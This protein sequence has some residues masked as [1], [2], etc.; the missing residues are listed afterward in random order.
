MMWP[1]YNLSYSGR[2]EKSSPN[3]QE[4]KSSLPESEIKSQVLQIEKAVGM[5]SVY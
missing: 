5:S 3:F 4:S 2:P 1:D